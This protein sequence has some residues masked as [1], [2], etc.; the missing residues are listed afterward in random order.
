MSLN[1]PSDFFERKKD[2]ELARK[3]LK[4]EQELANKKVAAPKEYFGASTSSA[5]LMMRKRIG[6]GILVCESCAC[7]VGS[8]HENILSDEVKSITHPGFGGIRRRELQTC[9]L[10]EIYGTRAVSG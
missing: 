2:E 5:G 6:L 1:K 8:K 4:E 3:K 10:V 9:H 7:E